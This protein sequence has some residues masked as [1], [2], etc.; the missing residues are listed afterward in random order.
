MKKKVTNLNPWGL[1]P[2][3]IQAMELYIETCNIKSVAKVMNLSFD[4][5]RAEL[6]SV[7]EKIGV[8]HSIQAAV[9]FDREYGKAPPPVRA[10]GPAWPQVKVAVKP[11]VNSIFAMGGI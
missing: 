8:E 7:R 10:E 3:E 6:R 4:T 2:R 11:M 9:K 5:I 1:T